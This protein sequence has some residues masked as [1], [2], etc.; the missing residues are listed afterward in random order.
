[1]RRKSDLRE[2]EDLTCTHQ[3]NKSLQTDELRSLLRL[4]AFGR[5]RHPKLTMKRLDQHEFCSF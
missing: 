4:M 1:V 2:Y 5:P 3:A